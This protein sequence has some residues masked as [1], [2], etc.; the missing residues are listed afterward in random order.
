MPLWQSISGHIATEF[1][2]LAPAFVRRRAGRRCPKPGVCDRGSPV[3]QAERRASIAHHCCAGFTPPP[4]P[5]LPEGAEGAF[6]PF[7]VPPA[8]FMPGVPRIIIMLPD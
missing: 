7:A 6:A 4:A 1:D 8:A 5:A 2:H 3:E